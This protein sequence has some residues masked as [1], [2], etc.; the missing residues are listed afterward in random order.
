M[1]RNSLK[2]ASLKQ[3]EEFEYSFCQAGQWLYSYIRKYLYRDGYRSIWALNKITFEMYLK[4]IQ[5]NE[6]REK[7]SR[8]N[9]FSN[10]E[11]RWWLGRDFI[12]E[13]YSYSLCFCVCLNFLENNLL[14]NSWAGNNLANVINVLPCP[15]TP[16]IIGDLSR[17][18]GS[19]SCGTS[20]IVVFRWLGTRGLSIL[21]P[22]YKK[23]WLN[24][25]RFIPIGQVCIEV[26]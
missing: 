10:S 13:I 6:M 4:I 20:D 18:V 25:H 7:W 3:S 24:R 12:T 22:F 17:K 1:W 14:K 26:S 5:Q 19:F 11:S 16:K 23:D 2:K 8:S 9:K 21:W 15:I